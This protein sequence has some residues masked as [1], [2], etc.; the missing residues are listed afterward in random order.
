MVRAIARAGADPLIATTDADGPNDRLDVPI[1]RPF[2]YRGAPTIFFRRD[3]S[4]AFKAS[5]GLAKWLAREVGGFDVVHIH[6]VFSHAS[7][8]AARACRRAGVPYVV[9]PLGTIDPWSMAVKPWRKRLVWA[10]AAGAALRHAA[11]IHYTTDGERDRAER[12]LGLSRGMVIPLGVAPAAFE[13]VRVTSPAAGDVI[14]L[15]RLDP[16]KNLEPLLEAWGDLI[17]RPAF[18]GRRLVIAGDGDPAYA[19]HLQALAATHAPGTVTFTGW[20]EGAAKAQALAGAALFAAPSHQENFGIAVAEALA[21]GLPVL[22]SPKV[23]LAPAVVEAGAGWVVPGTRDALRDALVSALG[24]PAALADRGRRAAAMARDR[25]D[26]DAIGARLVDL[27]RGLRA[28][29]G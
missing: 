9:R 7:L 14:S 8:V 23:D 15:G 19:R 13:G 27:Y 4:E 11:V 25:F 22:L 24:D 18:A 10:V 1:E 3:W 5:R 28:R 21:A 12:S 20:L 26:W 16:K 29:H 6:A 2:D 17:R